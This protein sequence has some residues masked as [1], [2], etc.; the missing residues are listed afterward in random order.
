MPM[1]GIEPGPRRDMELRLQKCNSHQEPPGQSSGASCLTRRL[2]FLLWEGGNFQKPWLERQPE[3]ILITPFPISQYHNDVERCDGW[4]SRGKH[5]QLTIG[6]PEAGNRVYSQ[7]WP[8]RIQWAQRLARG[9]NCRRLWPKLDFI[10]FWN[11][12]SGRYHV[13]MNGVG[14]YCRYGKEF[15][16]YHCLPSS[17]IFQLASRPNQRSCWGR[18]AGLASSPWWAWADWAAERRDLKQEMLFGIKDTIVR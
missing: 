15:R 9:T 5:N 13:F 8:S 16:I 11:S 7:R 3:M 4:F 6:L 2:P 18:C 10:F 14:K 12:S 1:P 17:S